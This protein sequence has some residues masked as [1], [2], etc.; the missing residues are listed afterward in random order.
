VIRLHPIPDVDHI[1]P[2]CQVRLEVKGWYIPGMRNLADLKCPQCGREFYGDLPAGHGLYYP[3]LLEQATGIVYDEHGVDWFARWLRDSYANRVNSPIGFT[4]EEFRPLKQPILL[5]CLDTLYGHCLLKLLN[6]QYYLDHHPDF[7]LIVII[8]R[9]LRWMVPDGVAAIWTV[10]LPLRRGAEWNDWLATEIKRRIEPLEK[11]WLSMAFAHPHPEDYDIE[12]FTRVRPFPVEEWDA[13]LERPTVT[14]IWREDRV[15]HGGNP[16]RLF[17]IQARKWKPKL[18]FAQPLLD[19]RKQWVVA[20]RRL[21][22]LVQKL[23]QRIGLIQHPLDEQ[24]RR[25]VALAQALRSTFPQI[26]FAVA[27]LG[28]PGG[29]PNWIADLR[30]LEISEHVERAWCERYAQSHVVIGVHGSNMLLP[31]AHAGAV[32]ELVPIERWGNLIQDI[33]IAPRDAREIMYRYRF[34]PI[35]TAPEI[36]AAVTASLLCYLPSALVNFNR[37]WCDHKTLQ[38]DPWLIVK[39]RH[40][41][42]RRL[43]GL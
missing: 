16:Q 29:L 26:D 11:C 10:D 7:D 37:P 28:R 18:S 6:A 41:I 8:P 5:N 13:R 22:W 27:G 23:G 43:V 24:K 9:F 33:L 38:G 14:Y 31:S 17:Q 25:V 35:D 39:R 40:K 12:R 2:Y 21:R 36:V 3:M 4:V 30:T 20:Y 42:T 32:V 19:K 15:W 34:L 1:C